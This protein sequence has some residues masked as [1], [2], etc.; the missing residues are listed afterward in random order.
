MNKRI[1]HFVAGLLLMSW[2]S[3]VLTGCGGGSGAT[4]APAPEPSAETMTIKGVA[5]KG[6]IKGAQV[7][8][9]LLDKNAQ[10]SKEPLNAVAGT[11]DANG[12]YSVIIPYTTE[13]IV[14]EII[15]G[16]NAS[17]TSE[18]TG[19]P[20][21]FASGEVLRAV[22]PNGSLAS[23][24]VVTP[25]TQAAYDRLLYVKAASPASEIATSIAQANE[26]VGKQNNVA[27]ILA[28]P[29]KSYTAALTVLEQIQQTQGATALTEL[30]KNAVTTN[31]APY[32][33]AVQ[34]AITAL[35]PAV[36][37]PIQSETTAMQ[38][39]V[40]TAPAPAVIPP[41]ALETIP[42]NAPQNLKATS[43]DPSGTS[44][45]LAWDAA[46][47]GAGSNIAVSGYE[48]YRGLTNQLTSASK[49]ASA[50]TT[51]YQDTKLIPDT[52]YYYWVKAINA[53]GIY[54][55]FSL[56]T[57]VKTIYNPSIS[58]T[59]TANGQLGSDVLALPSKDIVKPTAPTNL[60]GTA[61][62]LDATNS[63]IQLSWNAATDDV[64]VKSYDIYRNGS[65]IAS[66]TTTFYQNSPV[67]SG[68]AYSYYVIAV[69]AAG[70]MSPASTLFS[71]TPVA[72]NLDI[73]VGGQ[74][75]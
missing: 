75:N 29:D 47:P 51:T 33:A 57:A 7:W 21:P 72:L 74:V 73:T 11:T 39:A 43:L 13:P 53:N 12:N 48:V 10:K 41:V 52:T 37:A 55:E 34:A 45:T 36:S 16:P 24:P 27:N 2:L 69:D 14:I 63:A 67:T 65:K 35:P 20:V 49:I 25:L 1:K 60:T 58:V 15:G 8:V 68:V 54:S 5:L 64:G 61:T 9:Y 4:T 66:T 50:T 71:I 44:L 19:Q 62:A 56:L 40:V 38:N 3:L 18:I 22:I 42:P 26:Y 30:L 31:A 70:N 28:A 6:P 59:V 23:N 46:T 32:Q 17:Y